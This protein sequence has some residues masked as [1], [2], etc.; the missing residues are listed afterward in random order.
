MFQPQTLKYSSR[1]E[2]CYFKLWNSAKGQLWM[3]DLL[4]IF[5][6]GKYIWSSVASADVPSK[7]EH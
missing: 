3:E 5:V 7:A 4:V 2:F 6:T 1:S